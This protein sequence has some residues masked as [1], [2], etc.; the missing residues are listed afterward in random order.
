M[1]L[2]SQPDWNCTIYTSDA[3][4]SC[5]PEIIVEVI[6]KTQ[7]MDCGTASSWSDYSEDIVEEVI[8][9]TVKFNCPSGDG[10]ADKIITA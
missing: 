8:S 1:T 9:G 3:W 10:D 5:A 6:G 7:K 2:H 4:M